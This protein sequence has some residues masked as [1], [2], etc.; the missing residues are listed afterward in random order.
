MNAVSVSVIFNPTVFD[1]V[2]GFIQAPFG[3]KLPP[4]LWNFPQE[5]L[6]RSIAASKI[7]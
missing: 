3:M 6:A 2:Q 1:I 7:Q 4:N 5:V